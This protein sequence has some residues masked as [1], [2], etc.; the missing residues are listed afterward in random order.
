MLQLSTLNNLISHIIVDEAHCVVSWGN[1]FKPKYQELG[2][3][4]AQLYNSKVL[5]LTATASGKRNSEILAFF[6]T[7]GKQ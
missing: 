7:G 4:Q 6:G 1:N 5:A 3:L 2:M